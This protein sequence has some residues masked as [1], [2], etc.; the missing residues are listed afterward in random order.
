M[1]KMTLDVETY[2]EVNLKTAGLYRYA[3]HESTDLNCVCWAFD[4]GPVNVWV[5]SDNEGTF[6]DV[7]GKTYG[8]TACPAEL[9]EHISSGGEIHCWNAAL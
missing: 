4:D 5:P 9:S 1:R 7:D 3:E 6:W 2:S 8:G